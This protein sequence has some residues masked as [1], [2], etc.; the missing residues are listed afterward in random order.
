MT[1]TA[2]HTNH[3]VLLAAFLRRRL[4]VIVLSVGAVILYTLTFAHFTQKAAAIAVALVLVY[5]AAAAVTIPMLFRRRLRAITDAIDA[6][7]AGERTADARDYVEICKSFPRLVWM[8]TLAMYLIGPWVTIPLTNVLS[9]VP[10]L[11]N[12][13]TI[14]IAS[15]IGGINSAILTFLAGEEAATGLVALLARRLEQPVPT[16]AHEP[17]GIGRRLTLALAA[18]VFTV[19]ACTASALLTIL[20]GV[21]AGEIA[22]QAALGRAWTA[23]AVA[24]AIS[25]AYGVIDIAFFTRSIARPMIIVTAALN[26]V[27][28]GDMRAVDTIAYEPRANHEAGD[29]LAFVVDTHHAVGALA[30]AS[31]QIAKGDLSVRIDVV[32]ESDLL[33]M[34][35]AR[36]VEALRHF[37]G[38]A[39][40]VARTLDGSSGALAAMTDQLTSVGAATD[41]DIVIA[42]SAT[43]MLESAIGSVAESVAGTRN[44]IREMK[45][46]ADLVDGGTRANAEALEH[47][48]DVTE[49]RRR[50]IME[51]TQANRDAAVEASEALGPI[52]EAG[53]TSREAA[54]VMSE[55][56]RAIATLTE[57]SERIGAITDTIDEISDQ[58]NLLALNAAIEAA[59][60]GEHGRGFA[61][62][63]DEIRKLAERSTQ[64]TREIA[65]LIEAVQR[66]TS[67]TVRV[68]ERGANAVERGRSSAEQ[69]GTILGRVV[70]RLN[71][72]VDRIKRSARLREE[73]SEAVAAVAT[74]SVS[75]RALSEQNRNVVERLNAVSVTLTEA[76]EHGSEALVAAAT[77]IDAVAG[78][79]TESIAAARNLATH[80]GALRDGATRLTQTV[81]A[82]TSPEAAPQQA[83][84]M[85]LAV[86]NTMPTVHARTMVHAQ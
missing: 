42:R 3:N 8:T 5:A 63:A 10:V 61:V 19:L 24:A 38:D 68:T 12:I 6:A 22:A 40:A 53:R 25:I 20:D 77:A 74:T 1:V 81:A 13:W 59:R 46:I 58:T 16:P 79:A 23:L 9:G 18:L 65:S 21:A 14:V 86:M 84:R 67:S 69:A 43:A 78:R 35:M 29:V 85:E 2:M 51:I 41:R 60:A 4:V 57:S 34:S 32:S 17:G 7:A 55:L 83:E 71:D 56:T 30:E 52:D 80:G 48:E 15:F 50:V 27:R 37:V 49:R 11:T 26:R 39:S 45:E 36:L 70:A 54:D 44:V 82:F 66:E 64:A 72:N 73:E 75:V 62:V 31:A 76:V 47:H 33:G 28:S